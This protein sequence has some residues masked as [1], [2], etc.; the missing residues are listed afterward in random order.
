MGGRMASRHADIIILGEDRAHAN[1]V[2]HHLIKRGFNH[3]QLRVVPRD[4][5]G[6]GAQFVLQRYATEVKAYRRQANHLSLALLTVIDADTQEVQRIQRRLEERL[7]NANIENRKTDE[8]I[9]ILIPKRNIETW[10]VY[11]QGI[12]VDEESDYKEHSLAKNYKQAG[13]A[14]A[15]QIGQGPEADC[16]QSLQAAWS[17]LKHRLPG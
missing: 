10:I 11:L 4:G 2:R 14:L 3:R 12:P 16:P 17:E 15:E 7:Q 9:A 8:R 1:F 6:S 5:S 13:I